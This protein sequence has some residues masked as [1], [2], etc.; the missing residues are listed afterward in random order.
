MLPLKGSVEPPH[1]IARC[2]RKSQATNFLAFQ[3]QQ[4]NSNLRHYALTWIRSSS[5]A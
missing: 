3:Q 4:D 5:E 1:A 2:Y